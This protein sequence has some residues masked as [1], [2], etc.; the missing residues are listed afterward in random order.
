[1]TMDN[2][3]YQTVT[4]PSGNRCWMSYYKQ[5]LC[6]RSKSLS[7]NINLASRFASLLFKPKLC[8]SSVYRAQAKIASAFLSAAVLSAP[9]SSAAP[10]LS[11]VVEVL[12]AAFPSEAS[13]FVSAEPPFEAFSSNYE[14]GRA[15]CRERV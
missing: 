15:S 11:A 10:F 6:Q 13:S 4:D 14:I 2:D 8:C 9:L 7:E 1:M 3:A 12:S 5:I